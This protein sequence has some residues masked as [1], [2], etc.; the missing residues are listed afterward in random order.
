MGYYDVAQICLNGH[1]TNSAFKSS[2]ENNVKFCRNCGAQT[3]TQCPI[4]NENITGD[5]IEPGFYTALDMD[6]KAP[7]FCHNCGSPYPWT[8][9]ALEGIQEIIDEERKLSDSEK[10]KLK[11]SLN[12]II[13]ETPKTALAVT[14][15]KKAAVT[16]GTVTKDALLQFA[17]D[18]ATETAKK[19]LGIN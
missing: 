1:I 15:F 2:S 5:Y 18:F 17:T 12:D 10:E 9:R 8:Q 14:R 6:E 13:A 3:I 4:C 19:M 7:A 11:L 16:V